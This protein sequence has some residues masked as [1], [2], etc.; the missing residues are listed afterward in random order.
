VGLSWVYRCLVTRESAGPAAGWLRW[1]PACPAAPAPPSAVSV[2]ACCVAGGEPHGAGRGPSQCHFVIRGVS[3]HGE[4]RDRHP[5]ARVPRRPSRQSGPAVPES[6]FS[7]PP[8]RQPYCPVSSVVSSSVCAVACPVSRLSAGW[9]ARVR[10]PNSASPGQPATPRPPA[11]APAA[12]TG[13]S[14]ADT[15][16]RG[17]RRR[18]PDHSN[19]CSI[20]GRRRGRLPKKKTVCADCRT[21]FYHLSIKFC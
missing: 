14:Q 3:T 4:P 11:A 6:E 2:C 21:R 5:S 19:S 16:P 17:G 15:I 1:R 9:E 18:A 7:A 10:P 20:S 12:L 13:L 8:A